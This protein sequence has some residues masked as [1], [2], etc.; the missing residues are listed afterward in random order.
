MTDEA[1]VCT[2][3]TYAQMAPSR[4]SCETWSEVLDASERDKRDMGYVEMMTDSRG[5]DSGGAWR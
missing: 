2:V 3:Q 4:V 5:R 1:L